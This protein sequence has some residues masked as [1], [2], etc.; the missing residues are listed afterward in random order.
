MGTG[1]PKQ[2]HECSVGGADEFLLEAYPR[3][4]ERPERG[5]VGRVCTAPIL[6]RERRYHRGL[7]VERLGGW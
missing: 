4:M 1:R 7:E 6:R 5:F 3:V 2:R